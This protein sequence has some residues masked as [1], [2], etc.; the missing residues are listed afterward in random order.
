M[1]SR[2][3]TSIAALTMAMLWT[4]STPLQAVQVIGDTASKQTMLQAKERTLIGKLEHMDS[5]W[6]KT[7]VGDFS[8]DGVSLVDKQQRPTAQGS[9]S[10]PNIQLRF[11]GDRLYKATIY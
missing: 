5:Q 2:E 3:T 1:R 8:R 4:L 9:A 10:E 6:L 11:R 7:S